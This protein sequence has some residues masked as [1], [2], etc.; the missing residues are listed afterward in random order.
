MPKINISMPDDVIEEI[1]RRAEATGTTRSGF[2]REAAAHYGAALDEE[3]SASAR[4]TRVLGALEKMR[5][6]APVVGAP[7]S[8]KAIRELRDASPRWEKR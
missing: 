4:S 1:D 6:L 2:L 5:S 7:D 8:D 3:A